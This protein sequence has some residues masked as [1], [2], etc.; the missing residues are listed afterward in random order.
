[1]R[2]FLQNSISASIYQQARSNGSIYRPG[3]TFEDRQYT[4]TVK[5]LTVASRGFASSA[6]KVS[7]PILESLDLR[8]VIG[9]PILIGKKLINGYVCEM[10]ISN[11]QSRLFFKDRCINL[12]MAIVGENSR[13]AGLF[14]EARAYFDGKARN[15]TLGFT[16]QNEV[17]GNRLLRTPQKKSPP[18]QK[19]PNL[20]KAQTKV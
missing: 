6:P 8:A 16:H 17:D 19:K 11:Q 1:M 7:D 14:E 9:L 4:L 2:T 20:G 3:F 15:S 10:G 5:Q 13:L 12:L 18:G